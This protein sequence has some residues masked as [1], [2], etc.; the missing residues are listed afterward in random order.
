SLSSFLGFLRRLDGLLQ[1]QNDLESMVCVKS[2]V[3]RKRKT[4]EKF[5]LLTAVAHALGSASGRAVAPL[6]ARHLCQPLIHSIAAGF[7]AHFR[8][9]RRFS[10]LECLCAD[11]M[12]H[13]HIWHHCL[14]AS[15]VVYCWAIHC[16]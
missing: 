2:V 8:L 15:V 9:C 16:T 12:A 1:V 10:G 11:K 3:S 4:W 5:S 14:W 13:K 7:R 6:A